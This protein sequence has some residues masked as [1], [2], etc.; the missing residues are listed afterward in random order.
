MKNFYIL[1]VISLSLFSE[2]W[3][4]TSGPSYASNRHIEVGTKYIG[5]VLYMVQDGRPVSVNPQLVNFH[6]RFNVN[7]LLSSLALLDTFALNYHGFCE[8]IQ[9]VKRDEYEY[10]ALVPA[11]FREA[12]FKCGEYRARLP[13][14]RSPIEANI[15][16]YEMRKQNITRTFAG[17][18]FDNSEFTYLSDNTVSTYNR[19]KTCSDCEVTDDFAYNDFS[20]LLKSQG[21]EIHFYYE[22]IGGRLVITAEGHDTKSTCPKRPLMC[23]KHV[24]TQETVLKTMAKHS[25]LRDR[26]EIK[27]TNAHLRQETVQFTHTQ[28]A[29]RGLMLAA[30]AGWMGI[31]AINSLV[32]GEAPLSMIGKGLASA[33]GIATAADLRLTRDQLEI[34]S[35]AL[36]DLAVN[37]QLL[38][39]AQN[40]VFKEV[41]ELRQYNRRAEHEVAILYAN[42]DNKVAIH[43]LQTLLQLT[44]LKMSTA[45]SAATQHHTSPYV[46]GQ[47][48]LNNL[49]LSYRAKAVHLTSN[50]DDVFTS[51]ALVDGVYTFIFSAPIINERNHFWFYE[52]RDLPVYNKGTQYKIK[53]Q[54]K[55]FAINSAQDEYILV[56]ETEYR[57]CM[58]YLVCPVAAPFVKITS[59]APCEINTLKFNSQHCAT[60][61]T[62]EPASN[63]ITYQ[64]VTYYSLPESTSIHVSCQEA[65]NA[66]GEHKTIVGTGQIQTMPGCTIQAGLEISVR[67]GFVASK[68][69]LQ[70]DTLFNILKV[71]DMPMLFPTLPPIEETSP[72]P[73]F[74]FRNVSSIREA[75]GVIF[76]ED[77]VLAEAVRILCGIG[78]AIAIF[79]AVYGCCPSFRQWFNGCCFLQKPTKYWRDVKGYQVPDFI[80]R[81]RQALA[82][83]YKPTAVDENLE[84]PNLEQPEPETAENN[85]VNNQ[86]PDMEAI[87]RAPYPF[88]NLQRLYSPL[89]FHR[90]SSIRNPA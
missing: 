60:E 37:Q 15:L 39:D 67:P 65:A 61:M 75:A 73:V 85:T 74:S 42:I 40:L 80:S 70:G 71:P 13:E 5:N 25:C 24:L 44:L 9:S 22:D 68:H 56:S 53:I 4:N 32:T 23:L 83:T 47:A 19:V 89:L 27:R 30:G 88:R 29:K 46:F 54:N 14:I 59:K 52:L 38:I 12:A 72:R 77:T 41:D 84:A 36:Q 78:I 63:F 82:V 35:Q 69:N 11:N 76:N 66:F 58:T 79:A 26:E 2:V 28:R 6:R 20:K 64:N 33:L 48:D 34:H 1:I 45:I 10:V 17:L 8:Q 87:E 81:H 62:E 3:S 50:L 43:N 55:Y 49:S 18:N 57:T 31:E 86:P 21:A 16:L 7:V 90:I 51:L